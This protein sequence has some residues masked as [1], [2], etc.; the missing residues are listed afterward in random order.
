MKKEIPQMFNKKKTIACWNY[1]DG[2]NKWDFENNKLLTNQTSV[3]K[4]RICLFD[5]HFSHYF[6]IKYKNIDI[7]KVNPKE[8]NLVLVPCPCDRTFE[9][10]ILKIPK[11][12]FEFCKNNNAK[13]LIS[14]IRE[15]PQ[16]DAFS[17]MNDILQKYVLDEGYDS[18]HLKILING[19]GI[20]LG[21]K[22]YK[23]FYI[24]LNVFDRLM[25]RYIDGEVFD[26]NNNIQ[27]KNFVKKEYPFL[28]ERKY[29]F[30]VLAGSIHT[31]QHRFLFLYECDINGLM[32]NRFFYSIICLDRLYNKKNIEKCLLLKF[33]W[34]NL[35][36]AR[37]YL[38]D[39]SEK[40]LQHRVYNDNGELLKENE[41][42]F[43]HNHEFKIPHQVLDS[44]INIVL[45][46]RLQQ[47]TI[48]EKIYK[49]I[50]AGIPFIW[51]GPTN[52]LRYLKSQGYKPY[53]F[54][55]YSF[56]NKITDDDK[57]K[58]LISEIKRLKTIDLEKAVY[59]EKHISEHNQKNF[60]KTTKNFD[61]FVEKFYE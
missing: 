48:T 6:N 11:S 26:K 22:K 17:R 28:K 18:R 16:K 13:I 47:P 35:S 23:D 3:L 32:D 19:Y 12:V 44:Y 20:P 21:E 25:R 50:V 42:I 46:T 56:D 53:S 10:S 52:T 4:Y 29:D 14:F 60:Y 2:S 57:I 15:Y 33:G 27:V 51:L 39:N 5:D 9:K 45:E 1:K 40:Y 38:Q 58:A 41:H 36:K 30:S 61:D 43:E 49:P 7:D 59:E 34:N 24:Y 55:D 37:K 31:N 54:I 8:V